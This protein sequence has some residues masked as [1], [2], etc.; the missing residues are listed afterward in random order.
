M[1]LDQC[2][3]NECDRG[4]LIDMTQG[5]LPELSGKASVNKKQGNRKRLYTM[6]KKILAAAI[7]AALLGMGTQSAMAGATLVAGQRG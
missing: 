2:N 4:T 3:D 6:S 7:G 1:Y 5:V